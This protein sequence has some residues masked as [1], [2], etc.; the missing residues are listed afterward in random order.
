MLE[1]SDRIDIISRSPDG[2]VNLVIT[3]AGITQDAERRLELLLIKLDTYARYVH[4]EQFVEDNPGVGREKARIRV[5]CQQPATAEME[6][7]REARVG[8]GSGVAIP[9]TFQVLAL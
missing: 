5:M 6:S 9:V 4:G 8:A 3:D 7:I 2:F 1:E